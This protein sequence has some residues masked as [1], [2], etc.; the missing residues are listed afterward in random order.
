[1]PNFKILPVRERLLLAGALMIHIGLLVGW[2]WQ[3]PLVPYFFDATVLN[4]GR[5][6]D[7]YAIYQAGY[8]ARHGVDI[9]E[10]DPARAP[11]VVPHFTPY[12]YLP[13]VAYTVGA[14]LSL[15][16]PLTAYK[17][18]VV[19]L[20]LTLW[21]CLALVYFW[22]RPDLVAW[23]RVAAVWLVFTPFYLELFMGQFSLVEGALVLGMLWAAERGH[24]RGFDLAWWAS[25]LWKIL[26]VALTPAL[27]VGRRWW[28]LGLCALSVG[29][30]TLPYFALFPAHALD[31]WRNNFGQSVQGHE[32]GNLGLRQLV[33]E[34]LAV[35]GAAP[36]GQATPDTQAW[37]QLALV[38]AIGLSAL[39]VTW[40]TRER[41]DVAGLA[42]VW[43]TAFLLASPQVWEHHYVL[44]L[45]VLTLAYLRTRALG[46]LGLGL[47]LA[48]P[49]PFGFSPL[50]PLIAANHDLRAFPL[51]PA[52]WAL[53]Q[54]ASKALPAL[55][56]YGYLL[57]TVTAPT[58]GA[59]V[60]R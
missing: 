31:F 1:M 23:A 12:R 43:L 13:I 26:T 27:L 19:V 58:A 21:G 54:H 11:I 3:M 37:A 7:F 2:R 52:G 20:T 36:A 38:G 32:L 50:Q 17:I 59:V 47:L 10:N 44:L 53:L 22:T 34:T 57:Y 8:N 14:A 30:T 56:L 25:V 15:V 9:Y 18:W 29:L 48:L 45:P 6:L 46:V 60:K 33:F 42:A 16:T 49:T 5:G 41:K 39:L 28:V 24:W 51:E 55:G 35:A 4:G 40:W